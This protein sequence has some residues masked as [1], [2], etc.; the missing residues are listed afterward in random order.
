MEVCGFPTEKHSV[1]Q[2]M[3]SVKPNSLSLAASFRCVKN[4]GPYSTS[5]LSIR[6]GENWL[7]MGAADNSM[8]MFQRIQPSTGSTT[9]NWQLYRT[10]H[11]T[12]AVVIYHKA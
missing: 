6:C 8:S 7:G 12:A 10:D 1:L 3:M 11:Q 2:F 5:V 4:V 9:G